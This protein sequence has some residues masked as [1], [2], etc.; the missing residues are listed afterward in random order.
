MSHPLGPR[1]SVLL[2]A[3]NE[4]PV[5]AEL[6]RRCRAALPDAREVLVI[7]DGS[8]DDTAAEAER[9]GATVLRRARN[10][11]KGAA[12]RDGVAAARG[13][14]LAFLDADGQD[15]PADL[16]RLL[17]AVAAGADLVVGSRFLGRFEPGAITPVN[18]LGNQ[19]LTGVVNALYGTRLT[20]TQAGF[21]VV[22]RDA[23]ARC[24]LSA[25][26]YDI[27][28]DL[29]LR[30]LRRGGRVVEVPVRRM[31]RAHGRSG[32]DSVRD[33]LRILRRIVALRAA[34]DAPS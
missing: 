29:L 3:H 24:G 23:A 9:A 14:L 33:G 5:I 31:P 4:G 6:V 2:P 21:R 19:F 32:L 34:G 15:D 25:D 7:D 26:R 10:G 22:S 11:G 12:V 8:R 16:P 18:R 27:E 13:E 20:D 28:V 1:T 30:T 17:D